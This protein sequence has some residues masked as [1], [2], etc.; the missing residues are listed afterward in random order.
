VKRRALTAFLY[1]V[2]PL[3]RLLGRLPHGL[4]VWRRH[5]ADDYSFPRPWA[6]DIWATGYHSGEALLQTI[7]VEQRVQGIVALRGN[8]FDRWDLEISGGMFGAARLSMA[9]ENHGSGRQLLRVRSWPRCSMAG[10]V[11][12]VVCGGL[13][14]SAALDG[15]LAACAV[16]GAVAVLLILR[17]VEECA[18]GSFAFLQAIKNIEKVEKN[19]SKVTTCTASTRSAAPNCVPSTTNELQPG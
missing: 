3:A 11:L 2:Q 12:S 19:R 17:T 7:E 8:A 5:P 18:F 9:L 4:T 10:S 14:L 15:A 16:L 13:S 1:L 6:A